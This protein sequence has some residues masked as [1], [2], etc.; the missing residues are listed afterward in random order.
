MPLMLATYLYILRVYLE[1][2]KLRVTR[3]LW[4]PK[5]PKSLDIILKSLDKAIPS[6]INAKMEMLFAHIC[7]II[8]C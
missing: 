5:E 1:S 2:A 7:L 3:P 4:V 6:L 8:W